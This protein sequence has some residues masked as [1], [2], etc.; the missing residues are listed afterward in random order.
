M[1]FDLYH[2]INPNEGSAELEAAYTAFTAAATTRNSYPRNSSESLAAQEEVDAR[3]AEYSKLRDNYF[4]LNLSGMWQFAQLL[5]RL[6]MLADGQAPDPEEWSK[7]NALEVNSEQAEAYVESLL[8]RADENPSGIPAHKLSDN[9]G[10]HVMP[11]EV[12]AALRRW[13]EAKARGAE[14]PEEWEELFA[15]WIQFLTLALERD[16]FRVY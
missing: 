16:G 7:A 8:S 3:W 11:S 10:W 6:G 14:I 2:S 1:G 9:S 5:D 15:K 4:R 12:A 13:E